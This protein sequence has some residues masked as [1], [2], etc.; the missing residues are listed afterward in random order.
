MTGPQ[1]HAD[2]LEGVLLAMDAAEMLTAVCVR[3]FA[4][5]MLSMPLILRIR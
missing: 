3:R 1:W 4:N 2:S 5:M